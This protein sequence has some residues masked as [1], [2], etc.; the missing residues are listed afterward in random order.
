M[1]ALALG[2][3]LCVAVS[4]NEVAK[5]NFGAGR[6]SSDEA[7]A[8]PARKSPVAKEKLKSYPFHGY[9]H[10]VAPDGQS[11]QLKGKTKQR[12]ILISPRTRIYRGESKVTLQQ[13]VSGERVTGS[14]HKNAEG[15]EE[16]LTVR[17]GGSQ[18]R[19]AKSRE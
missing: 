9:L 7:A 3:V 17:L 8:S 19:T 4:A 14:V 16:A 10:A 13:A 15:R 11:L 12:S 6:K 5:G 1:N 18:K 2:L